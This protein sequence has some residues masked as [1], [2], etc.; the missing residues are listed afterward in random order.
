MPA[1]DGVDGKE[2]CDWSGR[3]MEGLKAWT[4]GAAMVTGACP[5]IMGQLSGV[6]P[7]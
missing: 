3:T 5:S 4:E 6:V 1:T 2:S 7:A